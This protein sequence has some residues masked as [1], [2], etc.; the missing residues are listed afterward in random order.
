M[1][2]DYSNTGQTGANG[3]VCLPKIAKFHFESEMFK[4]VSMFLHN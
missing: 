1:D 2:S 4:K 3:A